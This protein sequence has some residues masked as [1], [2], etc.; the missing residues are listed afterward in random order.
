MC[1]KKSIQY[2]AWNAIARKRRVLRLAT[3]ELAA[4]FLFVMVA[5][6]QS[7][8]PP[9]GSCT[10]GDV[11][12]DTQ[13]NFNYICTN[14]PN[15]WT[16]LGRAGPPGLPGIQGPPGAQG[17]QGPAGAPGLPGPQGAPGAPGP[18]GP[19]GP[20]GP[21][22]AQGPAVPPVVVPPPVTGILT[23]GTLVNGVC[24]MQGTGFHPS[25]NTPLVPTADGKSPPGAVMLQNGA[26][27]NCVVQ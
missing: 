11:Y 7:I 22:G 23:V 2:S 9:T 17:P 24:R 12:T 15:I 10:P 5:Q 25:F 14:Q 3:I 27:G 13:S 21:Q 8:G 1:S 16:M 18:Q 4:L 19:Q 26:G 6:A 20:P